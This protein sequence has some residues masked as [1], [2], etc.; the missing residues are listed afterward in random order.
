MTRETLTRNLTNSPLLAA[1][2]YF[3]IMLIGDCLA[4]AEHKSATPAAILA[5]APGV[6]VDGYIVKPTVLRDELEITGTL[7][8]NQQVDIVSELPRKI[9]RINVKDGVTVQAGQLLFEMDNADLWPNPIIWKQCMIIC[10][11]KLNWTGRWEG[12][13]NKRTHSIFQSGRI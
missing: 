3:S 7:E 9:I 12:L 4:R 1:I 13:G 11:P 5:T 10:L 6:P 8:P 2:A